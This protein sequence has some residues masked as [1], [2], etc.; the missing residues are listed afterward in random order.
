MV[1]AS[2]FEVPDELAGES[3]WRLLSGTV[4]KTPARRAG[5][6]AVGDS[7]RLYSRRRKGALEHLERGVLAM[8]AATGSRPATLR[9]LLGGHAPA[10][11]KEL[12]HYPWYVEA[13]LPLPRCI[14]PTD[15]A[16]SANLLAAGLERAAVRVLDLRAEVVFP[17]EFNRIVE[18]VDNKSVMLFGVTSRLLARLWERTSGGPV[19]V[20][21]D[22]QG[23]R[24]RYL[25]DLQRV[26]DGCSFKVLDETGT[27][28]AYRMTRERRTADVAFLVE[29]EDRHL[30][31]ALASMLSKYLRELLMELF[32]RFWT[33]RLPRIE[34][35]AGYYVD[36]RRFYEEI[37]PLVRDFGLDERLVYRMR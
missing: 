14:S 29:A 1:S 34:P 4:A 23:G 35:T 12:A 11:L 6:I 15:L 13:D 3:M 9:E 10:S 22:R 24:M 7:K 21:V 27:F 25:R 32:N 37:L 28:S 16:L 20:F 36:G 17:G 2:A 18:A 5:A 31:V 26:F 8:L 30:P 33:T 19:R